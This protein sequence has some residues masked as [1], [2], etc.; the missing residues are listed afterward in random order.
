MYSFVSVGMNCCGLALQ[1]VQYKYL[2]IHCQRK[3]SHIWICI[4]KKFPHCCCQ[5]RF[6]D[7]NVHSYTDDLNARRSLWFSVQ[8][9]RS[10]RWSVTVEMV[11][12]R[13]CVLG[14]C[15][16]AVGLL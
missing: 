11:V 10:V 16:L 7:V 1:S 8:I 5:M 14:T 4:L 2:Q 12:R 15:L 9:P 3:C 6:S 13:V